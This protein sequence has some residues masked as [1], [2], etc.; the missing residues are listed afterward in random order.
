MGVF[1]VGLDEKAGEMSSK[2]KNID[3]EDMKIENYIA[4]LNTIL[5]ITVYNPI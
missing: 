4:L 5:S 3:Y 1:V 2:T